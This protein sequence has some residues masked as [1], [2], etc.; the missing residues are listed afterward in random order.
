MHELPAQQCQIAN[1]AL[2]STVVNGRTP[3]A[4]QREGRKEGGRKVG[5]ALRREK[6]N[7]LWR[8]RPGFLQLMEL[9]KQQEPPPSP[10]TLWSYP[11]YLLTAF[12]L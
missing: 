2:G 9:Q 11:R 1:S 12:F 4:P 8:T 10:H 3:L 5:A 6:S 7:R